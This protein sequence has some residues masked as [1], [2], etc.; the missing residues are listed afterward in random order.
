MKPYII[1]IAGGSASGKTYFLESIRQTFDLDKVCII[2]QDDYYRPAVEQELD[3]NG[4][5][6]FDLPQGIND[7]EFIADVKALSSNSTL[8]KTKYMFNQP[9]V[10]GDAYLLHPA[11]ILVVE[12]LFIFYFDRI[13]RMLDLSI[14][15]DS[16][17]DI[18]LRRRL[19]R[20][21]QQ[22][23]L[24]EDIIL[25]QWNNHVYPSYKK[26]LL[27]YR[28]EANL[29]ITNNFEFDKALE[30]VIDHIAAKLQG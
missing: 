13:K 6:N 17:D 30:V 2:S 24:N 10:L 12:G 9:E 27:P 4:V 11:Q 25:Y 16:R 21:T 5:I 19:Q 1:G 22:R 8:T 28:D 7:E 15:M 26:Y 20:D 23:G 18:K 29:I 3:Q 14:F